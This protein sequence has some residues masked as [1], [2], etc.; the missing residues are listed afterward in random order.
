MAAKYT[1][2]INKIQKNT[3]SINDIHYDVSYSILKDG[4]IFH[5]NDLVYI[6]ENEIGN[7]VS[8]V[9]AEAMEKIAFYQADNTLQYLGEFDL[10]I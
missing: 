7:C 3:S 10:D 2:V 8:L 5:D 6:P 9:S 1:C 4:F